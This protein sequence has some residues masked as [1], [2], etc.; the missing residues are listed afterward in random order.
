MGQLTSDRVRWTISNL[1]L[2]PES[3]NRLA[4]APEDYRWED[5]RLEI[6]LHFICEWWVGFPTTARFQLLG[7]AVVSVTNF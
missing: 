2:L 4:I 1:E 6:S 7:T 3:S 5:A